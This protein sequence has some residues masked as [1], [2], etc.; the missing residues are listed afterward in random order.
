MLR[1][2]AVVPPSQGVYWR[3]GALSL[4]IGLGFT[5]WAFTLPGLRPH[6]FLILCW[7]LPLAA[8]IAAGSLCGSIATRVSKSAWKGSVVAAAG[9]TAVWLVAFIN[10]PGLLPPTYLAPED[11]AELHGLV[12]LKYG[13]D[14]RIE[15]AQ[16]QDGRVR[17]L[18]LV[19]VRP[20]IRTEVFEFVARHLPQGVKVRIE[21]FRPPGIGAEIDGLLAEHR[22]VEQ[23]LQELQSWRGSDHQVAALPPLFRS[24]GAA[25][26]SLVAVLRVQKGRLQNDNQVIVKRL[27]FLIRRLRVGEPEPLD[28]PGND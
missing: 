10:L 20:D 2:P 11:S 9:G 15:F 21:D 19:N 6:Q 12:R 23:D 27:I 16:D 7:V 13:H 1:H 25:E 18:I 26:L 24:P 4:I 28:G 14:L 8:G 5:V 17:K 3:A 22:S